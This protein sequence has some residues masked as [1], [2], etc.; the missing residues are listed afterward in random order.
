MGQDRRSSAPYF[1]WVDWR[2]SACCALM[3]KLREELVFFQHS[4]GHQTKTLLDAYHNFQQC[5]EQLHDLQLILA[6]PSYS[7]ALVELQVLFEDASRHLRDVMN[8]VVSR[9][10]SRVVNIM[11]E[12]FSS[13]MPNYFTQFQEGFANSNLGLSLDLRAKDWPQLL[14]E[15]TSSRFDQGQF[16][17]LCLSLVRGLTS[18]RSDMNTKAVTDAISFFD[19]GSHVVISAEAD[20][21]KWE[22]DAAVKAAVKA[23]TAKGRPAAHIRTLKGKPAAR[24]VPAKKSPQK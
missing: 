17:A 6:G 9:G 19:H 8:V 23:S 10:S 22:A 18:I 21:Q 1:R 12:Y 13:I 7:Q 14:A 11:D 5:S 16:Y 3:I 2:K 20:K 15:S 24:K 4:V